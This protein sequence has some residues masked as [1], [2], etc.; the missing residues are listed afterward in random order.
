MKP[1][2]NVLTLK[3]YRWSTGSYLECQDFWRISGIERDVF[4]YSQ[5][6]AAL[7]DFRVT[8]TL[9]DTYKDGIFKLGV[10]LRN[11]GSTAGNMTLVYEL[12]DANGKVVATG[13]SLT[14][15]SRSK[16]TSLLQQAYKKCCC[17]VT[18]A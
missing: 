14:A 15:P 13:A 9:D 8:S 12:L 4:L 18:Q 2:K 6:K 1:G 7:K 3:I 10:D 17:K 5:P 11:N 16:V